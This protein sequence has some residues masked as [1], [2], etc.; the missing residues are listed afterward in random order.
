MHYGEHYLKD[1]FYSYNE[2][3]PFFYGSFM[4]L[5]ERLQERFQVQVVPGVS[6]PMACSAAAGIPLVS[7]Q[8]TLSV[9]PGTLSEDGLAKQ[10]GQAETAVIMKVGRHFLKIRGVIERLGLLAGAV[11]VERAT[12]PDQRLRMLD[13]IEDE[14]VPYFSTILVRNNHG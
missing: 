1:Y 14:Q 13:E 7:H 9:I 5:Y 4:Y 3:D 11:C 12:F 6:S 10:L 8:D 2:G